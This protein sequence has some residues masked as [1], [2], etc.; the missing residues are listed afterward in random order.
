MDNSKFTGRNQLIE[1]LSS[2]VGDRNLA[3][4]ILKKRGYI[5][6]DGLTLTTMGWSR[7]MMSAEERAID[8][9]SKKSGLPPDHFSYNEN[10]N[11]AVL[12]SRKK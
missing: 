4:A 5:E 1:R 9:R 6:E 7:N 2:Q 11:K 10:T 8:R 12:K 3:I